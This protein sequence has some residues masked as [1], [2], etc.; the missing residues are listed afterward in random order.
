MAEAGVAAVVVNSGLRR[1]F[2][3]HKRGW[4]TMGVGGRMTWHLLRRHG[5]GFAHYGSTDQREKPGDGETLPDNPKAWIPAAAAVLKR[6]GA[7]RLTALL[8]MKLGAMKAGD[9][10]IAYGLAAYLLEGRSK[11]FVPFTLACAKR[12][13]V[14]AVVK[15]TLGYND[16]AALSRALRRWLAQ[17]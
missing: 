9:K 5:P 11:D 3:G 10:L 8:T 7:R 1:L 4:I 12:H 17:N 15:E 2:R 6:D 13:D 14:D 16:V